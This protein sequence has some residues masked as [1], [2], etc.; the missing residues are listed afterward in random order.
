MDFSHKVV[1]V[2]GASGGLGPAVVRY[3]SERSAKVVAL[4]QSEAKLA[5]KLPYPEVDH[6]VCNL[7]HAEEVQSYISG[8]VNKNGRIDILVCVAGA[9]GMGTEVHQTPLTLWEKLN[10]LNVKTVLNICRA[11][12]PVME[13]QRS[14]KVI[15]I[16]ANAAQHGAPNMG[17]YCAAKSALM[18]LTEAMAM[19]LRSKGINVNAVMPTIIDTPDNRQ[20]MPTADPSKWVTPEDLAAVIGFLAS[21]QAKAVHGAL[22]PVTGLS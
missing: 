15:T 3:F 9:F 17:A 12:I 2:T 21:D 13:A 8:I 20:A 22:I 4:G 1:V 6:Q 18:R 19:E 14:G 16:G 7:L 11:V 10:D 5:E